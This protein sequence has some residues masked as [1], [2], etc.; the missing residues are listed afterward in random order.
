MRGIL[1]DPE[2][3]TVSEIEADFSDFQEIQKIID[4]FFTT[5]GYFEGH[6]AFVHDEGMWSCPNRVF[7]KM[8]HYDDPLMG[9]ILLLKTT[10]DGNSNDADLDVD[11]VKSKI[12]FLSRD[13]LFEELGIDDPQV[14]E[15]FPVEDDSP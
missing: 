15:W 5:A 13:V 6:I 14:S 3:Q 12:Q 7:T 4:G 9:K 1:I 10:P 11:F 2:T 8:P